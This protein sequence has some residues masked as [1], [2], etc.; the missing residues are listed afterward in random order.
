M[1]LKVKIYSAMPS[2]VKEAMTRVYIGL[3]ARREAA[4]ARRLAGKGGERLRVVY[5]TGFPRSGTTMLKYYFAG[6]EGLSQSAFSP[7]GFFDVWDRAAATDGDEILVD[8]SN[9]YIYSLEPL[10]EGC[11]RGA[12]VVVILRD[13]RDCLVSFAK[14]E[15]NREVPRSKRYWSYWRQ[16]HEELLR[17]AR[18]HPYGDC[19]FLLRYEDLVRYPEEAKAAFL[20]WIGIDAAPEALDRRYRNDHPDEGWHDSVHDFREVG[21]H[22]FQKWRS[23][24]PLPEWCQQ[25]LRECGDHTSVSD[26]MHQLGYGADDV[27]EPDID[28]GKAILFR[29]RGDHD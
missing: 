12:R 19:L 24:K 3:R 14:Y 2:V 27:H 25:R 1:S 28:T 5:V 23:E 9:H 16:Q 7:V 6:H 11:A 10:F 13:P 29:P 18:E 20:N 22:A 8:K 4:A 21:M 17:F 26:L 15:E